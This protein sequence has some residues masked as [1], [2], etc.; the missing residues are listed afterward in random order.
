MTY[1]YFLRRK[2]IAG[3]VFATGM[4]YGFDS[5]MPTAKWITAGVARTATTEERDAYLARA[6]H[7]SKRAWGRKDRRHFQIWNRCWGLV[8]AIRKGYQRYGHSQFE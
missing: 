2:V 8:P 3:Q 7:Y 6:V 1:L 5:S 4:V